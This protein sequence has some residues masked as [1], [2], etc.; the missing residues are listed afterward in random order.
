MRKRLHAVVLCAAAFCMMLVLAGCSGGS[1]YQPELKSATV[2]TPTIGQADTLRV[3]VNTEKSPLAGM[4][5]EKIIGIDVD[6]AAALADELG[7]KLS[8][9][10]VGS[11]PEDALAQGKVD[12]VMGI[13]NSDASNFWL[14]EEYLPTGVALFALTSSNADVPDAASSPKIAAQVSSKSAWA[15]SNEFGDEALTST[16]NLAD[17]FAQLESG[18]V[19]YVASDALI[20]LYAA[21]RAGLDTTVVALM[22]KPS[23]YCVGVAKDNTALQTTVTDALKT[24][25]DQGVVNVIEMKWL[26]QSLDFS[27]TPLTAGATSAKATDDGAEAPA[28]EGAEGA[29]GEA[30]AADAAPAEPAPAAA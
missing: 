10:D 1:T 22:A 18:K 17:A 13:D 24:L 2:T 20:G 7:L 21:H 25:V 29:E 15:V 28:G 5:S 4:G 23:G 6:I 14:S 3:G 19:Q 16:T 27:S 9:V 26:G 12:I 30:P 11:D 8:I